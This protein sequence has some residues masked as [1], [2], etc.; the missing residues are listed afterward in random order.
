MPNTPTEE[1]KG[2]AKGGKSA[3]EEEIGR[4]RSGEDDS[5]AE[6][7]KRERTEE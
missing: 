1:R 4:E 6:R 5:K 3:R 2:G 7:V